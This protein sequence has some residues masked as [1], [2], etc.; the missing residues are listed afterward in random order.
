MVLNSNSTSKA[1]FLGFQLKSSTVWLHQGR[2]WTAK[3]LGGLDLV[4]VGGPAPMGSV[5]GGVPEAPVADLAALPVWGHGADPSSMT[6]E[7]CPNRG[8][9]KWPPLRERVHLSL[10]YKNANF[11]HEDSA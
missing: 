3:A 1:S 10:F 8:L 6:A 4:A 5:P 7:Y 9:S 11:I 2:A